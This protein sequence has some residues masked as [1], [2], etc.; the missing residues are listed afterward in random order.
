M[1]S[2]FLGKRKINFKHLIARGVDVGANSVKPNSPWGETGGYPSN[3]K[4]MPGYK[5][6]CCFFTI[7]HHH[8][9]YKEKNRNNKRSARNSNM[10]FRKLSFTFILAFVH[11]KPTKQER[12]TTRSDCAS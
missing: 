5:S 11:C 10:N 9:H 7:K 1:L 8:Q 6:K 3:Y 12:D 2:F 4:T